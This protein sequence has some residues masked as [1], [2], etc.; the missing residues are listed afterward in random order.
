[1]NAIQFRVWDAGNR[2]LRSLA[3]PK[4]TK[5][6]NKKVLHDS[7]IFLDGLGFRRWEALI[8]KL[9]QTD[10]CG[11]SEEVKVDY[12]RGGSSS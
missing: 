7:M 12:E 5:H 9:H 8:E 4:K 11:E 10:L 2:F 6:M 3:A 1:M